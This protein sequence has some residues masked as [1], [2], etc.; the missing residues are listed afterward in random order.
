MSRPPIYTPELAQAVLDR[1][2]QGESLRTICGLEGMPSRPVVYRW[3][4]ENTDDF[5]A[6]YARARDIG[7]DVVADQVLDIADEPVGSTENGA[8]DSGAV[9]DKRVRFDARR[10]YLSKLAPK[11]SGDRVGSEISGPAGGPIKAKIL[12]TTGVPMPG[13]IDISDLV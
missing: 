1:L 12:V 4:D 5:A 13:E 6:R 11:R 10:W 3:I 7:L 8:T 9:A 2:A